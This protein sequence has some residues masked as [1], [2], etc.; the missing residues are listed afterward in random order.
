MPSLYS[1]SKTMSQLFSVEELEIQALK[2]A[3]ESVLN[4]FFIEDADSTIERWEKEV[5]IKQKTELTIEQRRRNV[6]SRL[7][8]YGTI[9]VNELKTILGSYLYGEAAITEKNTAYL[10]EVDFINEVGIPDNM[11]AIETLL[12]IILPAHLEHKIYVP[13]NYHS[14][15]GEQTY[16]AL[17]SFTYDQLRSDKSLR[18]KYKRDGV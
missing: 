17:A 7:R 18:D 1:E 2:N 12:S 8:G 13:Y 4:Q 16:D 10:I 9:T 6:M 5:G 3:L 11:E 14:V 15:F